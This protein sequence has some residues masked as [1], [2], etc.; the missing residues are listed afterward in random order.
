MTFRNV[1]VRA[2][3]WTSLAAMAFWLLQA[4]TGIFAV[5]HW[6]LDDLLVAGPHRATDFGAIERRLS[7]IAL[8]AEISSI[9]TTAG[10]SDR[11]DVNVG[12]ANGRVVRIDGDGNVLRTRADGERF[13]AGGFVDTL[14]VL[15]QSLL[16]GDRG[17]W[18][19]GTSGVLLLSNL[20]LG[21][22]AAWPRAGQWRRAIRPSRAGSR[23][24][25]L[26][27][28]HRA[29]GLWAAIP[30]FCLVAAGVL[31]S[32]KDVTERLLTSPAIARPLQSSSAVRRVGMAKA[33][34]S[35]QARYPGAA[36]SGIGFP[37][38]EDAVWTITLKQRGEMRRAYGK[39]RVFVSAIDGQ[40]V[41]EFDALRA[42]RGRRFVN[43]LFPF[44]TGEM[45]GTPGRIAVLVMGLW[46]I[47]MIVLG[48]ALWWTRRRQNYA[49]ARSRQV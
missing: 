28:W 22:I 15:H 16:A 30:S 43:F 29:F 36:V 4:G 11:Y 46:L 45:G 14:V 42:A 31:M 6:E 32:F 10:A 9:W 5:F 47:T 49:A 1:I 12:G 27:S 23:V 39:T 2:H 44:H 18:I 33:V 25:R 38:P 13:A 35:A 37:S 8:P 26:Y 40:F 3:R 17:K 48:V 19:L 21:I 34:E 41:A 7:T 24:A 20:A